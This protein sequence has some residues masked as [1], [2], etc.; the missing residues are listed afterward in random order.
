[1]KYIGLSFFICLF[2]ILQSCNKGSKPD[3]TPTPAIRPDTLP[4]GWTRKSADPYVGIYYGG[5]IF[6]NNNNLVGYLSDNNSATYKS[7]DGGATWHVISYQGFGNM[8][9]T[10]DGKAFFINLNKDSIYRTIDG[11]TTITGYHVNATQVHDIFF[12][13]NNNGLCATSAGIFNTSDG[14]GSWNNITAMP[15]DI[16]T[17]VSTLFMLNNS[18]AWAVYRNRVF[19][20][21]GSLSS[22]VRDTIVTTNSTLGLST[23]SATSASVVYTSSYTGYLYKSTDGGSSFTLL[24]KF[25]DVWNNSAISD[26]HFV[27]ANTGFISMGSRIY[28][29]IDAG[30]TW[31]QIVGLGTSDIIEIHF[32]DANHGWACCYDGTVLKYN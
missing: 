9:V 14:G 3:P 26:L 2:A 15:A 12:A 23:V 17:S 22:W 18:N 10:N 30:N 5:D 4:A 1:M 8:A 16:G 7:I 31:S 13:D 25:D 21:S 24:K 6:F 28:K 27:D 32:T 19:H 11:G 29:T 20:T